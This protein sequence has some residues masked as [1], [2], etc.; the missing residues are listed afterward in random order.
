MPPVVDVHT[1]I[2]SPEVA[3]DLDRYRARDTW[4]GALNARAHARIATASDLL[5]EMD[6]AG[7]D[8]SVACGWGW[9]EQALCREQND[10]LLAAAR[11]AKGRILPFI[12]VQ[13]RAPGAVA[14]VHRCADLGAAGIGEMMPDGQGYSIDDADLLAPIVEA[15][16]QRGLPILTHTSEP[17][18]RSY[19][20]KGT[21]TPDKIL[22]FAQAFPAAVLICAHWGG[23]LPFYELMPEVGKT[24]AKVFYDTAAGLFLYRPEVYATAMAAV[25]PGKVLFGSDFPLIRQRRFVA[26]LRHSG[27]SQEHLDAVLGGNAVRLFGLGEG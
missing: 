4:F 23:G 21:V 22:R 20:G 15:A 13:P 17:L 27:L 11:E 19:P 16:V 14:E 26:H 2:F 24:L 10:Y 3:Q 1:H 12:S 25:G 18:G 5:A 9:Q 8:Y 6:A 7:V